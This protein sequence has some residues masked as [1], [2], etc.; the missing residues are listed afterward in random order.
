M[1]SSQ[2]FQSIRVGDVDLAHRVVFAPTTRFRADAN[3]VPL[4][5]VAEYY[6]QR[7]S[8]PGSLLISE[9]TFIALRAGIRS[10]RQKTSADSQKAAM[11]RQSHRC[12]HLVIGPGTIALHQQPCLTYD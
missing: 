5:H 9:A 3:H 8:T 6:E 12:T 7:A 2:L 1:S 4:P 11:D 10:A